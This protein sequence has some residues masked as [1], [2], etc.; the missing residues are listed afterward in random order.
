M[1][2]GDSR[3]REF[4]D[5]VGLMSVNDYGDSPLEGEISTEWYLN[6]ILQTGMTPV[7]RHRAWVTDA[8]IP[9]G[10]RSV[11]EHHVIMKVVEAASTVDQLNLPTLVSFEMLLRRAQLIEQAHS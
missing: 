8:S 2:R 10:D 1:W 9:A 11:H 7:A 6:K 3:Y 5:A 4:R